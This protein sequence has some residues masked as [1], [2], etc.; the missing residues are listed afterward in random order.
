MILE[1]KNVYKRASVCQVVIHLS[2]YQA[3]RWASLCLVRIPR[4]R[5]QR[6][7]QGGRIGTMA[8]YPF[9]AKDQPGHLNKVPVIAITKYHRVG[10]FK[11]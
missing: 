4:L 5:S 8:S 10:G 9:L 1:I 11:H 3:V 7:K 6:D 2:Q